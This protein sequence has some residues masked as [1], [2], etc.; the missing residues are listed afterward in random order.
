MHSALVCEQA[1]WRIVKVLE[2]KAGCEAPERK[3]EVFML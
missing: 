3:S 2:V 1:A